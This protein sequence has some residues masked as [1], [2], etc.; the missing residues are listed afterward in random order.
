MKTGLISM[1]LQ[2]SGL[3]SA[4]IDKVYAEPRVKIELEQTPMD[5]KGMYDAIYS[6]A[7]IHSFAEVVA[8]M[9]GPKNQI[10]FM[11]IIDA[12]NAGKGNW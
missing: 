4:D 10:M 7:R 5:A 12:A 8:D 6:A 11:N 3:S 9:T 2:G 1:F